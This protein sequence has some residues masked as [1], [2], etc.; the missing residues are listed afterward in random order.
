M[1]SPIKIHLPCLWQLLQ[2][3]SAL[4]LSLLVISFATRSDATPDTP[5]ISECSSV[6]GLPIFSAYC[7]QALEMMPNGPEEVFLSKLNPSGP[8]HYRAPLV[9]RLSE[10]TLKRA[11]VKYHVNYPV[12]TSRCLQGGE[13]EVRLTMCIFPS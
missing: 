6:Y 10:T 9:S 7:Y 4:F 12:L 8:G 2:P 13:D 1:F 5:D 11:S 3:L